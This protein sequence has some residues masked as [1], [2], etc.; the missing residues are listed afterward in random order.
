MSRPAPRAVFSDPHFWVPLAVL[1]I[2]IV[3][4]ICLH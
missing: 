3:L 2:G 1:G 4:I